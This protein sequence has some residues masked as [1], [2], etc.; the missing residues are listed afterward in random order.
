MFRG[1]QHDTPEVGNWIYYGLFEAR[2]LVIVSPPV[3]AQRL[4]LHHK[5]CGDSRGTRF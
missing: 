4:V 2:M 3:P 1:A 5:P